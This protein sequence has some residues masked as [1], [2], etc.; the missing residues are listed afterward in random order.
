LRHPPDPLHNT[1]GNSYSETS[2]RGKASRPRRKGVRPRR[3]KNSLRGGVLPV[4]SEKGNSERAAK[5]LQ[6][7]T[8]PIS[9]R[10]CGSLRGGERC[11][12]FRCVEASLSERAVYGGR[13]CY[14]LVGIERFLALRRKPFRG[15]RSQFFPA[16][17]SPR[18]AGRERGCATDYCDGHGPHQEG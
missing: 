9:F 3:S 14:T 17:P 6:H 8:T 4:R 12:D 1:E 16:P 10:R 18:H 13:H 2:F 5:R 15:S 7:R 11:K